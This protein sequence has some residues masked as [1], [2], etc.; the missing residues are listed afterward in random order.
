MNS[1]AEYKTLNVPDYK[2]DDCLNG[3]SE[4]GWKLHSA[5]P[6]PTNPLDWWKVIFVKEPCGTPG[7]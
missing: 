4:Q 3:Y 7:P 6:L 2:L 1:K 5:I